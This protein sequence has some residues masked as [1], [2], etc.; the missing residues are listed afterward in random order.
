[1]GN[2]TVSTDANLI[3]LISSGLGDGENITI[4]DGAKLT[5][6]ESPTVL[7]GQTKIDDGEILLD[8]ANAINPIV[9]VGEE[10]E[11]INVNGAGVLR[12]TLGWWNFPTVGDGTASQTFDCSTYFTDAIIDSDVFSGCWVETGRRINYDNGSGVAPVVGDWVFL[13]SDNDVHGRIEAVS[14]DGTTGYIVVTFLTGVVADNE[15]IELH[16]IQDNKGPNYEKSWRAYANGSDTLESG[17]YQ[18]FGNCH[19][20]NTDYLSQMGSGIAGFAFQQPWK[21]NTLTFG[22]GTTGFIVP[23]GAHVRVPMVHIATGSISSVGINEPTWHTTAANK[24]ELETING[25]DC[26]LNGVSL[27]SAHFEDNLGNEFQASY[28]SA[29]HAFGVYGALQRTSYDNCIFVSSINDDTRSAPRSLPAIADL[30]SGSDITDCLSIAMNDTG[31]YTNMGGQTSIGLTFTRCIAI[32]KGDSNEM[33]FL[34]V[35]QFTADDLVVIGTNL[36]LNTATDGNIKL[37]K[38]QRNLDGTV[39]GGDQVIVAASTSK[40]KITGWEVLQHSRP[41][42]SMIAVSDSSFI[43]T[44]CFHFMEDKFDNEHLGGSQGEEFASVTGLSSDISFSRCWQDGGNPNEFVVIASGTSKNVLIQNCSAEYNGEIEPDG[45]D[46]IIRGLH[47]G[48]GKLNSVTGLEADLIGTIGSGMNDF[49]RSNTTGALSYNAIPSSSKYPVTIVSGNPK[50][51]KDGNVDSVVGD[52]WIKEFSYFVLGHT[53]FTGVYTTA[54]DGAG[55]PVDGTHDW[56]GMQFDFQYDTGSGYN[57]E[58]LDIATPSNLTNVTNMVDGI[59]IKIRFTATATNKNSQALLLH[60]TTTLQ[61]QKANLYPIDQVEATLTLTGLKVGSDVVI[62]E[63]GT[64]N[65]LTSV[66]QGGATFS[67]TYSQP[68]AV[69]IGVIKQGYVTLYQYGYSLPSSDANLP[70][71]Q[72]IDRNYQ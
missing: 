49:F 57:E 35:N 26:Y 27:G 65:V 51:T 71:N 52:V 30:V 32:G 45:I 9:Y 54:R 8:G 41:D 63:A 11:E 5:I 44:R 39:L 67:Y 7:I 15:Q 23:N 3:S 34:R 37:L 33:E 59:K 47:S 72:L 48:S 1:M 31:E 25:G 69:D 12:S 19:Q 61:A 13:V 60:T 18:A 53:S 56:S 64:S 38:T 66:D 20:N 36:T 14:G 43:E 29:N 46:T 10:S 24:H 22:N 62:L 50:F 21:S 4:I 40:T 58:W 70:I 55:A 17:V 2:K 28:C 6:D 16:T 42:D 68:Q